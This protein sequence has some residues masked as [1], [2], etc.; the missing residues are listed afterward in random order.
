MN[1]FSLTPDELKTLIENA[2]R[3]LSKNLDNKKA[4]EIISQATARLLELNPSDGR[5]PDIDYIQCGLNIGDRIIFS[6][7]PKEE[8]VVHSNRLLKW[9]GTQ[10]HITPLREKLCEQYGVPNDANKHWYVGNRLLSEI[11]DE[12]Y[13]PKPA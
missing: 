2:R 12:T 4:E 6:P 8:I 11:Y 3:Q 13:G 5:R 7:A 1:I 10:I 9:R